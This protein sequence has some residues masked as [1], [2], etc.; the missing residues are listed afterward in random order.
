[1][2]SVDDDSSVDSCSSSEK[3]WGFKELVMRVDLFS[4]IF[5][6][7]QFN[8]SPLSRANSLSLS[9]IKFHLFLSKLYDF[10]IL[11][12]ENNAGIGIA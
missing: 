11:G 4:I 12:R 3:F 8:L 10:L 5:L 7:Y 2:A 1:M 9:I 6:F